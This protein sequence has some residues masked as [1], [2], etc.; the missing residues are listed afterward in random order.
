MLNLQTRTFIALL[1]CLKTFVYATFSREN[2]LDTVNAIDICYTPDMEYQMQQGPGG[3]MPKTLLYMLWKNTPASYFICEPLP[4]GSLK[5][6][7]LFSFL[8]NLE[9]D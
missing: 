8:S 5:T 6:K 7:S 2:V 3:W 1:P 4:F 9:E